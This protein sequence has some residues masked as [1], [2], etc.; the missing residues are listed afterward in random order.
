[1]AQYQKILSS[2]RKK[3][4]TMATVTIKANTVSK[5]NQILSFVKKE[6]FRFQIQES[7]DEQ[8]FR[9]MQLS[10]QSGK[11]DFNKVMEFLQA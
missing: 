10:E 5:L 8:L 6:K 11:G 9:E 7:E 4:N 1:V 2:R 3:I